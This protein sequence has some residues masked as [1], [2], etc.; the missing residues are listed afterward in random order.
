[1]L[2]TVADALSEGT[3]TADMVARYGGDE[4]AVL[5]LDAQPKDVDVILARV[6]DKLD[7]L[8]LQRRLPVAIACST[9]VAWSQ[10]PP[11]AADDFLRQADRDMQERKAHDRAR[12]ET[13]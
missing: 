7:A 13:A 11:E 4:F 5:L 1:V 10:N 3:R 6:R 2:R 9:G 8:A 12:R